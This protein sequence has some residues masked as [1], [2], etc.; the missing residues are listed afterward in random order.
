MA[1][2]TT[3]TTASTVER[4]STRAYAALRTAFTKA[5]TRHF[6]GAAILEAKARAEAHRAHVD[7]LMR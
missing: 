1:L 3:N 7:R 2:F 4:F 6:D 5:W